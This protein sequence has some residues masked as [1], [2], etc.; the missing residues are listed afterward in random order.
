[1]G[2][3]E[4]RD[5]EVGDH[6]A[7]IGFLGPRIIVQNHPAYRKKVWIVRDQYMVDFILGSG[8]RI[9]GGDGRNV[10]CSEDMRVGDLPYPAGDRLMDA[11]PWRLG[12]AQSVEVTPDQGGAIRNS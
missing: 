8:P 7:V 9:E 1:M 4:T 11:P 3:G 6:R 12:T 10:Q 2:T 5:P